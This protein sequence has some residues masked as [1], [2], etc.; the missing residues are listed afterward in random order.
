MDQYKD[1][2]SINLGDAST[3]SL[4]RKYFQALHCKS[5]LHMQMK[6]G[7]KTSS[8]LIMQLKAGRARKKQIHINVK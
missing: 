7:D 8:Y 1:D 3:F 4:T 2:L 5:M 6:S